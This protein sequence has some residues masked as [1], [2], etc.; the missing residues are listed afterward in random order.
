MQT[1][2]SNPPLGEIR[3]GGSTRLQSRHHRRPG[4]GPRDR[5]SDQSMGRLASDRLG[6]DLGKRSRTDLMSETDVVKV[7]SNQGRP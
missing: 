2:T 7:G 3:K 5:Q 1:G 4:T 6:L